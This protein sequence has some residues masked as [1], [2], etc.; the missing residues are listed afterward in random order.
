MN[1]FHKVLVFTALVGASTC[2]AAESELLAHIA[3][4]AEIATLAHARGLDVSAEQTYVGPT[5]TDNHRYYINGTSDDGSY[6]ATCL[7]TPRGEVLE[8]V[9]DKGQWSYTKRRLGNGSDGREGLA[10]ENRP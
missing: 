6:R 9:L 5:E 2:A 3:C 10:S 8:A 7:A 4:R 1:Q